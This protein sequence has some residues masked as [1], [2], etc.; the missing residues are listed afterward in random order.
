MGSRSMFLDQ[1]DRLPWSDGC[2]RHIKPASFQRHYHVCIWRSLT[3]ASN[4]YNYAP[5]IIANIC[6]CTY[7]YISCRSGNQHY[8]MCMIGRWFF[9]IYLSAGVG[10]YIQWI[11]SS[12]KLELTMHCMHLNFNYLH[13]IVYN[14]WV[15]KYYLIS[16][17]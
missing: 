12:S 17:S 10:I 7:I 1:F 4:I 9:S 15:F 2:E 5:T 3:R 8:H 11:N 14:N 13:C 16:T 6:A